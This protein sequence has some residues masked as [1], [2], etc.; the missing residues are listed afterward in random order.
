MLSQVENAALLRANEDV[1]SQ[2]RS[3]QDLVAEYEDRI[4]TLVSHK[5][6]ADTAMEVGI[7]I[8]RLCSF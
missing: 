8:T 4:A 5:T 2:L 6:A 1:T 3:E 7:A